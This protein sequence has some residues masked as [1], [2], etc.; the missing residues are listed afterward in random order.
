ML[1]SP[2]VLKY[3]NP[4]H[5]LELQC[6]ASDKG[7]GACL[8]QDGQPIAYAS[9]SLTSAK[10]QYAKIETD[11]KPIESIMKKNLL[12]A[13]KRL[14]RMMLRLQKYQLEV[15]YKRGSQ[16]FLVDTL[17][18]AYLKGSCRSQEFEEEVLSTESSIRGDL[19][20]ID[21]VGNLAISEESLTII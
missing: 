7:L 17:S 9:R 14:Q 2:P 12:C 19:E 5:L 16:M 18:R 20:S 1:T 6:D 15:S 10:Q 8:M 3:F 21:M 11:H 13:P 4:D